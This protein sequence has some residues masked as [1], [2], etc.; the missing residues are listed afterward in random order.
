MTVRHPIASSTHIAFRLFPSATI[1]PPAGIWPSA[2]P[3]K[4]L[5]NFFQLDYIRKQLFHVRNFF[6]SLPRVP[7]RRFVF[8]G[9]LPCAARVE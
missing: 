9:S 7:F 8:G 2:M 6:A 3:P 5:L 4:Y 1:F